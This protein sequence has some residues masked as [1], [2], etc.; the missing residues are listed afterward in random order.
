[1][2]ALE[3]VLSTALAKGAPLDFPSEKSVLSFFAHEK[4][5]VLNLQPLFRSHK[6]RYNKGKRTKYI[7]IC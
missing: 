4:G 2:A 1:M 5:L 6:N 3:N 7:Y